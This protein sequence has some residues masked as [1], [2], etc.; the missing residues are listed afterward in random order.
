MGGGSTH[1]GQ[2]QVRHFVTPF[3]F[4]CWLQ[5]WPQRAHRSLQSG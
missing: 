4:S 3:S 2:L 5:R 1:A